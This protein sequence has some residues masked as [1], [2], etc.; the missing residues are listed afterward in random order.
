MDWLAASKLVASPPR[1]QRGFP[2]GKKEG[3][4]SAL[5]NGMP[6]AFHLIPTST[7]GYWENRS[8]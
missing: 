5:G 7:W 8:Q 6:G 3:W 1:R 2:Q 4:L